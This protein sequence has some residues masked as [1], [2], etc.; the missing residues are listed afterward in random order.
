MD[1]CSGR[2][3]NVVAVNQKPVGEITDFRTKAGTWLL[4]GF[5]TVITIS[6]LYALRPLPH[7]DREAVTLP[8]ARG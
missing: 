7:T 3:T 6:G 8:H 5:A 1:F 4:I 2:L